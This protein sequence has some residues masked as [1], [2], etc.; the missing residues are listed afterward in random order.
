M[1]LFFIA[2]ESQLEVGWFYSGF[3]SSKLILFL[4]NELPTHDFDNFSC[5]MSSPGKNFIIYDVLT[6]N[7]HGI[8]AK[9]FEKNQ[10]KLEE[11]KGISTIVDLLSH[12]CPLCMT[13]LYWG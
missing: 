7:I 5:K 11:I 1:A 3:L 6:T 12:I 4:W 8:L 10:S 9:N 2:S 13:H